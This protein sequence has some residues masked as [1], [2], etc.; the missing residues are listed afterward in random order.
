MVKKSFRIIVFVLVAI[1][2]LSVFLVYGYKGSEHIYTAEEVSDMISSA[3]SDATISEEKINE[4]QAAYDSLNDEDKKSVKNY[5]MLREM[6]YGLFAS[7]VSAESVTAMIAAI[8]SA[9]FDT[10]TDMEKAFAAYCLL[11]VAE[12]EKVNNY[13]KLDLLRRELTDL[14]VK[15]TH[16]AAERIDRSEI[17]IGT[18]CFNQTSEKKVKEMADCGIDFV[19]AAPSDRNT[20]DLFEKYGI[21]ALVSAWRIL[22]TWRGNN[23]P[24]GEP[25]STTPRFT[26]EQFRE[27]V[28]NVEDHNAIWGIDLVDEPHAGDFHCY[29]EY[30]DILYDELPQLEVYI[31]LYPNYANSKQLGTKTYKSHIDAFV[32]E[33]DTDYICYDHYLYSSGTSEELFPRA[34]DNMRIVADAC[35]ESG[36]DFWIVIQVNSTDK[37]DAIPLSEEKLKLQAFSALAYGATVINWAC[38]EKGWWTYNVL[39]K[40]GNKTEQYEKLKHVNEILDLI[41]PV[42][43]RYKRIDTE[44]QIGGLKYENDYNAFENITHRDVCNGI[45]GYF[46]KN[47]GDGCAAMFTNVTAPLDE[48][49]DENCDEVTFTLKEPATSVVGYFNGEAVRLF[50]DENGV[51]S[52]KIKNTDCVFVT[53]D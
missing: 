4:A 27:A 25:A 50:P 8:P 49:S 3:Y 35:K 30:T 7:N 32:D 14:Y 51:Y 33:I 42:F 9:S 45:T 44:F 21:G 10:E 22:P 40:D 19:A 13:E 2:V 17:L 28:R 12:R 29:K 48:P 1:T 6:Q 18:Y 20:L 26:L 39:D 43:M 53:V 23:R 34:T 47:V 15:N 5:A 36:R 11:S 41:S 24:V 37:E 16:R 52:V 31:N 38:W 46:A